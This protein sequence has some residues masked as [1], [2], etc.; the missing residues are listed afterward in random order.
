MAQ[1]VVAMEAKLLAVFTSGLEVNVS[2]LCRQLDV[3]RPTFYKYRRRFHAEGPPGLIERRRAP[4]RSPNRISADLEEAIVRLR[5]DLVI[6]NGAQAIAYHLGRA[7]LYVP[8]V[9]TI[10]RVLVGR[11][12]VSPQPE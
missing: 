9:S 5:K 2:E 11:G 1:K 7:G 10:H 4:K 12:L 8:A 6:D 3:S